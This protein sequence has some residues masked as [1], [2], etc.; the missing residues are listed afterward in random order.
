MAG[1]DSYEGDSPMQPFDVYGNG[2]WLFYEPEEAVCAR[3]GLG[4]GRL[5]SEHTKRKHAYCD[6]HRRNPIRPSKKEAR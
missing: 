3:C 1:M 6:K 4:L 2:R 5:A